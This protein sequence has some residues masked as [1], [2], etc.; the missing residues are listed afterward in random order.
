MKT[1]MFV[2]DEINILN[3]MKRQMYPYRETWKC[4]FAGS[5]DQAFQILNQEHIDVVVSDIIMPQTNGLEFLQKISVMNPAIYRIILSGQVDENIAID[6]VKTAH[7]VFSKPHDIGDLISKVDNIIRSK[8]ILKD[9]DMRATLSNID[10]IPPIPSTITE[11]N[12]ALSNDNSSVGEI[13]RIISKDPAISAGLLKLVNSP[14]FSLRNDIY[15][16]EQAVSMLG[17]ETVKGIS[18]ATISA[19]ISILIPISISI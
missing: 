14:F 3:A 17:I 7:Q 6:C 2:D 13:G 11:I 10:N 18:S 19:I 4:H 8:S 5:A 16:P 12:N 15:N 1:I 9:E